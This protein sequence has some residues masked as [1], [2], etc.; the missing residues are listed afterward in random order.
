MFCSSS[1]SPNCW[2]KHDNLFGTCETFMAPPHIDKDSSR[3]MF[4]HSLSERGSSFYHCLA[5]PL[6][7]ATRLVIFHEGLEFTF[8]LTKLVS[9]TV[10]SSLKLRPQKEESN[11]KQHMQASSWHVL[12]HI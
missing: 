10:N 2:W 7:R 1:C 11:V 6:V 4:L 8:V 12:L 9:T 3:R 5:E